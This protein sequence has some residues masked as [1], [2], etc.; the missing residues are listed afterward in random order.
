M[1]NLLL[2]FA[3]PDDE[4]RA[5]LERFARQKVLNVRKF[6][7]GEMRATAEANT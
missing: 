6:E 2:R 5:V 4:Q 7:V 1:A 3:D